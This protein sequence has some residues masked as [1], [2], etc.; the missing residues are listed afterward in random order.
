MPPEVANGLLR[1]SR[2]WWLAKRTKGIATRRSLGT[3][4]Q[5]RVRRAQMRIP[6]EVGNAG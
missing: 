2:R 3:R 6:I 5:S 4:G 1:P